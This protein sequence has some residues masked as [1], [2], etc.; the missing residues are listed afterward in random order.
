M[1]ITK[2]FRDRVV[3][4]EQTWDLGE[5][6][7]GLLSELVH[8]ALP[9]F[10]TVGNDFDHDR[11]FYFLVEQA[12]EPDEERKVCFTR[13]LLADRD[14]I[15]LIADEPHAPIRERIVE[16][17]RAQSESPEIVVAYRAILSEEEKAEAD[18]IDAAWRVEEAAREAARKAEEDRRREEKRRQREVEDSRRRAQREQ[19]RG[20]GGE[21]AG[22]APSRGGEAGEGRARKRRR[23]RGGSG[24]A[25]GAPKAEGTAASGGAAAPGAPRPSGERPGGERRGDRPRG[26][27]PRGDRPRGDRPRPQKG[28]GAPAPAQEPQ[29]PGSAPQVPQSSPS[30]RPVAKGGAPDGNAPREGGG[31]RRRRRRGR[32]GNRPQGGG[33]EGGAPQGAGGE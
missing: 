17:I 20:R 28:A 29:A 22:A 24:R 10:R 4:M 27:R 23:G 3:S 6:Y 25:E 5:K 14:C 31:N 13:M 11:D 26:E 32:S 30:P 33:P 7:L 21:A 12:T 8:E 2:M 19:Q 18:E 16:A 15:P 1:A 9:R